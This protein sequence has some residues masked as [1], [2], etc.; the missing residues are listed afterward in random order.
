MLRAGGDEGQKDIDV[1]RC[2]EL[3]WSRGIKMCP[4]L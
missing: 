3:F 1:I 2:A 4:N